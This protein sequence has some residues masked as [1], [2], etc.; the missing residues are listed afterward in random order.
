MTFKRLRHR[1]TGEPLCGFFIVNR[2]GRMLAMG[3][4]GERPFLIMQHRRY[5][6]DRDLVAKCE[7]LSG[8]PCRLS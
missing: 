4:D 7:R 1:V 8:V 5:Q 6:N 2:H 3:A